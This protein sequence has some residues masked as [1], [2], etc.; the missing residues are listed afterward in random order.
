MHES[1]N[2]R[3]VGGECFLR[4]IRTNSLRLTNARYF[5]QKHT[6]VPPGQHVE[7]TKEIV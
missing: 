3:T 4:K 1:P 7:G 2:E 5:G 6:V